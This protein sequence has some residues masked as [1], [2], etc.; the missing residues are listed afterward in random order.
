MKIIY[1]LIFLILTNCTTVPL[2]PVIIETQ[3]NNNN[4]S[5]IK[6][7]EPPYEVNG[8]WF[9]PSDYK[10]LR[11]VGIAT[12]ID[13]IKNGDLTKNNEHFHAEVMSAAHRSLPLPSYVKVTN[14]STG[15]FTK[16]RVNHRGAFSN[17]NIIDLSKAA[18][19]YLDLS[20]NGGLVYIDLI[21]ENET[22]I[23]SKAYTYDEEKK[24][25][26]APVSNVL[27]IDSN[28]TV[29]KADD[30]SVSDE[31]NYV[32]NFKPY[33]KIFIKVAKFSQSESAQYILQD[34]QTFNPQ[35][36]EQTD[37]SNIKSYTVVIGPFKNVE[38]L[39]AILKKDTFDKY[40][41]LS[42]FLI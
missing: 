31:T 2:I 41:D 18:F 12:K 40:E 38:D 25:L 10:F 5:S 17:T 9:Y 16:V 15:K 14:A 27:I 7:I 4:V 11:E 20:E 23:L 30:I 3:H 39:M 21:H 28:A 1:I 24:V 32:S 36:I 37:A 42:I 13:N 35:V 34:L 29:A 19:D 26:E 33:D 6:L 22:F 8:K